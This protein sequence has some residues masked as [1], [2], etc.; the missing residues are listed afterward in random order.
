M[1]TLLL[2]ITLLLCTSNI[3]TIKAQQ[4][5]SYQLSTA[6]FIN[7]TF[8]SKLTLTYKDDKLI[9]VTDKSSDR[10]YEYPSEWYEFDYSQMDKQIVTMSYY[11]GNWAQYITLN[12]NSDGAVEKA[13]Y[14]D[15]EWYEFSYNSDKQLS[16]MVRHDEDVLEITNMTYTNGSLVKVNEND[17]D[18]FYIKY[19]SEE[20]PTPIENKAGLMYKCDILWGIDLD[21]FN[22]VYMAGLLGKAPKY[23]PTA[24]YPNDGYE[25]H[26]EWSLDNNGIPTEC[27]CKSFNSN[28]IIYKYSWTTTETGINTITDNA[29]VPTIDATYTINGTKVKSQQ[30]GLNII[31]YSNGTIRKTISK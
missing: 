10:Y 4:E 19:T 14:D 2:S 21:E 24:Q 28:D 18:A 30:K 20:V 6:E 17:G 1:K 16:R 29:D 15:G 22:I 25:T 3:C 23:L 7:D 13:T 12:L 27:R 11:W 5:Q 8:R 9:N 26:Y 31:R